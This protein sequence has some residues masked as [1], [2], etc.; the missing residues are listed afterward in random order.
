MIVSLPKIFFEMEKTLDLSCCVISCD[1]PL[2]KNYWNTQYENNTT[3]WDLGEATLAFINYFENV[4]DKNTAILIP[5][6]GNAH[7]AAML[8]SLG[9]KN[10]TVIDI[11]PKVVNDL[12][13]KFRNE[14]QLTIICGDF[15]DL[16]EHFDFIVEQTFFCALPPQIREKYVWKMHELLKPKG[17]LVGLLFNRTFEQGPP[18]GGSI[19]EYKNLFQGSFH[20]HKIENCKHSAL[21]R[22]NTECWIEFEKNENVKLNL[23]QFEGITCMGC[24]NTITEKF[25]A[26]DKVQQISISSDFKIVLIVSEDEIDLL[27]LQETIS[28]EK[29]YAL[30]KIN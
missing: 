21:P 4:E 29:H 1:K 13:E 23:Y 14:H 15:F 26:I 12:K 16:K 7:E 24:K 11:A 18:F 2:D 28:Y 19:D 5:G 17:K 27:V 8:L 30:S 6:C 3:G 10:I 20:H 22:A 25:L 9:F